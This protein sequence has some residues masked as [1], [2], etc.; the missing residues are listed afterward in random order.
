MRAPAARCR[1]TRSP[2]RLRPRRAPGAGY[3]AGADLRRRL[4]R[5]RPANL[6]AKRSLCSRT[7][8]STP[9][10]APA[11][12]TARVMERAASKP[13]SGTCVKDGEQPVPRG[14]FGALEV[15]LQHGSATLIEGP[16][17]AA[18]QLVFAGKVLVEGA[19]GDAGRAGQLLH[20]GGAY[21]L[22]IE[23]CRRRRGDA[24]A[25][26]R[27]RPGMWAAWQWSSNRRYRSVYFTSNRLRQLLL[28]ETPIGV[29]GHKPAP[30]GQRR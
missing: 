13:I 1:S 23:Q 20:A 22:A 30:P 19:F 2:A 24:V 7:M 5:R 14:E 17:I 25:R 4:R 12:S 9:S 27:G 28:S 3:R 18:D 8:S 29:Q 6:C 10:N 21:S 26:T 16:Q 15:A 11:D